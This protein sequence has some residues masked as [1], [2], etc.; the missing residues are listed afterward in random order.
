DLAKV[1]LFQG[2][3]NNGVLDLLRHPILEHRLLAADLLQRQFAA[4]VV[5]LLEAVEA[6]AAVA[7]HLAGLAHI[8]ELLGELQQ[9][10]LGADNL[11][12]GRHGVLNAPRRGASPPRPLR[13]PPRLAIRRGRTRTPLSY[14]V[15]ANADNPL[16]Q[17]LVRTQ[18][19]PL[20]SQIHAEGPGGKAENAPLRAFVL[21]S[22]RSCQV[23]NVHLRIVR[24]LFSDNSRSIVQKGGSATNSSKSSAI[25]SACGWGCGP[26][27]SGCAAA[28]S[29]VGS[30][31]LSGGGQT[32]R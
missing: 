31:I 25:R 29:D 9:S 11:L 20:A 30:R 32:G 6:V 10:N 27:S 24:P 15:S 2:E 12:F 7:H 23:S 5:K 13:A 18:I 22:F 14:Q 21:E 28:A 17:S 8:A 26:G 4:F 16:V 19:D 3:R 1:G